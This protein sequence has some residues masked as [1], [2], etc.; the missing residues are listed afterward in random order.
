MEPWIDRQVSV[1]G[2]YTSD[3]VQ[4]PEARGA[5]GMIQVERIELV[6]PPL[7]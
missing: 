7:P 5:V 2:C 3:D 4:R 1:R 6:H